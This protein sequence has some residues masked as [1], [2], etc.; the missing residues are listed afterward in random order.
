MIVGVPTLTDVEEYLADTAGSW[1]LHV[2]QN[3]L[4]AEQSDQLARVKLPAADADGNQTYPPA[5]AE[6]L[7]RRV[8]HNLAARGNPLGV[9]ATV[10]DVAAIN[11]YVPGSDAEVRR[12]EGPWRRRVVG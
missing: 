7:C 3:V 6:A 12:L 4:A 11:T 2:I 10:T 9:Q 5:L 1:E 8:A